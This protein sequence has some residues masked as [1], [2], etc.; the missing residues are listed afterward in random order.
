[1]AVNYTDV[2]KTE[3]YI[4][5]TNFD[6]LEMAAVPEGTEFNIVDQ[7]H[8][9]DLDSDVLQKLNN[10]AK[11]NTEN[12]FTESN[13]FT[14]HFSVYDKV[15]GNKATL[16]YNALTLESPVISE[17]C[18]LSPA[19]LEHRQMDDDGATILHKT[20]LAF[21]K[22]ED[23]GDTTTTITVPNKTGT[24]ALTSDVVANPTAP[25]ATMLARLKV[26]SIVYNLPSGGSGGGKVYKHSIS[27]QFAD[28]GNTNK[29]RINFV[30]YSATSEAADTISK[31]KNLYGAQTP[32]CIIVARDSDTAAGVGFLR[33]LF[34]DSSQP[35]LL[36]YL[37]SWTPVDTLFPNIEIYDYVIEL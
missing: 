24:V 21:E 20:I 31:F 10:N 26:G 33:N 35:E 6:A 16:D 27:F 25:G 32:T 18:M 12:T 5:R 11:I 1:M 8:E 14:K 34:N 30:V 23:P 2:Q 22:E 17:T 9:S 15:S 19:G 36:G 7:I 13:T 3:K 29:Y 4:S 28:S 37:G